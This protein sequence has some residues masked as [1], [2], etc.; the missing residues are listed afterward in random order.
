[1][2]DP[3]NEALQ[4]IARVLHLHGCTEGED[5]AN[6]LTVKLSKSRANEIAVKTMTEYIDELNDVLLGAGC[7]ETAS[8]MQWL[9]ATLAQ[10]KQS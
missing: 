8:R 7:P 1:M 10:G 2:T 9:R 5:M 3:S 4:R 6:W